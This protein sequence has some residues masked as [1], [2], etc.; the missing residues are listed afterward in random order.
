LSVNTSAASGVA[1]NASGVILVGR[2]LLSILFILA[3]F[4]KLTAIAGTAGFFGSL[5]LPAPT[6]TAV[7]VGLIELLGGLSI[8][9]GFKTRIAAIVLAQMM[10]VFACRHPLLPA[11]HYPLHEN[12]LLLLALGVEALLLLL[13]VYTPWGNL[14]FGTSPLSLDV[15][16]FALPF[17]LL[18]GAA[19]ELRKWVMR[20]A[21]LTHR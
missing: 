13:I 11:W 18:L 4:G 20:R 8:L 9:V 12:R 21:V 3:G 15:W 16:L 1:S 17:A 2:I 5:G 19:E 6:V 10:N 14:L 7:I